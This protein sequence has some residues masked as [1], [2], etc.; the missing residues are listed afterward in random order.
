MERGSHARGRRNAGRT[1]QLSEGVDGSDPFAASKSTRRD[2]AA[3]D[4]IVASVA[5][6]G[7]AVKPTMKKRLRGKL[8]QLR[9]LAPGPANP[10]CR[11]PF[12]LSAVSFLLP[13]IIASSTSV[14][15]LKQSA[16]LCLCC[17]VHQ[18]PC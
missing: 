18:R 16:H 7:L 17:A 10:L 12:N 11:H 13:L 15:I 9:P 2:R 4:G 5:N 8:V 1:L 14:P 6:L 3:H